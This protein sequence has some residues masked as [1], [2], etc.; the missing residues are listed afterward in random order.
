MYT[1]LDISPFDNLKHLAN[2]L[3]EGQLA[4]F[5]DNETF[6]CRIDTAEENVEMLRDLTV[7]LANSVK[8]SNIKEQ[9]LIAI[10]NQKARDKFYTVSI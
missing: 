2:Q 5:E 9:N 8:I 10:A 1:F 6:Q 7:E 3:Y 4:N